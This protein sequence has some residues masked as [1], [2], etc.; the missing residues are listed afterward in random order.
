MPACF[1]PVRLR[2]R[3]MRDRGC[4]ILYGTRHQMNP[5]TFTAMAAEPFR[6]WSTFMWKTSEM[7]LASAQVIG[8]RTNPALAKGGAQA[9]REFALMGTEKAGAAA[10]SLQAAAFSWMQLNQEIT[11]IVFKQ[12]LAGLAAIGSIATSRTSGQVAS[13]QARLISDTLSN[14]SVAASRLSG[15]AA[16]GAGRILKP[17]HSRARANAK[18]LAKR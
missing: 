16:R 4:K 11:A 13:R 10:E 6:L 3:T 14:S 1:D 8:Y 7:M 18:R 9:Q 17:V 12:T 2:F 5:F 15:V